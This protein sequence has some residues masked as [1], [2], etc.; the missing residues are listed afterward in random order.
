MP[1]EH[2]SVFVRLSPR[3][4]RAEPGTEPARGPRME[5]GW[6]KHLPVDLGFV[7]AQVHRPGN[8]KESTHRDFTLLVPYFNPKNLRSPSPAKSKTKWLTSRRQKT[9]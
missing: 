9:I 4:T 5:S 8:Q 7:V 6:A 1:K 3:G 2:W